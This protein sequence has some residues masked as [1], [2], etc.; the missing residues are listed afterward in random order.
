MKIDSLIEII[1]IALFVLGPLAFK[2]ISKLHELS[3]NTEKDTDTS[4][5]RSQPHRQPTQQRRTL[6]EAT[7]TAPAPKRKKSVDQI[8]AEIL[9]VPPER[10][11]PKPVRRPTPSAERTASEVSSADTARDARRAPQQMP[12]TS[13]KVTP[14]P[15]SSPLRKRQA[16]SL[17]SSARTE[18]ISSI[19]RAT[20]DQSC[21]YTDTAAQRKDLF[22]WQADSGPSSSDVVRAV[23][24]MTR[25]D[26]QYAI[27]L[28][29]ILR[30]PVSMREDDVSLSR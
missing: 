21:L 23:R 27:I 17:A 1:I 2:G 18:P 10:E 4:G 22:C 25:T 26:W 9:G 12:S 29:E 20:P 14:K 15:S 19:A 24:G 28:Q 7:R 6:P 13:P 11:T 8:M 5:T 3:R 16:A 30:P